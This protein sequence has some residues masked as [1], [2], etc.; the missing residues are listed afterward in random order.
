MGDV[1]VERFQARI[2]LLDPVEGGV[3][4]VD[5]LA[6]FRRQGRQLQAPGEFRRRKFLRL[7]R[8]F[9]QGLEADT[10]DPEPQQCRQ[11]DAHQC[12]A[13]QRHQQVMLGGA[14]VLRVDGNH[15]AQRRALFLGCKLADQ[16][17]EGIIVTRQAQVA[18]TRGAL[19][20]G[21]NLRIR[22][23]VFVARVAADHPETDALVF[24]PQQLE[25]GPDLGPMLRR[26]EAID[27]RLQHAVAR[28]QLGTWQQPQ[29]TVDLLVQRAADQ[30]KDQ[31]RHQ[32]EH[33]TQAQ[34]DGI[35]DHCGFPACD[36]PAH[37][38]CHEW[39]AAACVRT[40]RRAWRA[41]A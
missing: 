16:H 23:T 7:I 37:S 28:I 5:E 1:G 26:A 19:G 8:E 20:K 30:Q 4:R 13:D 41:G 10:R 21:T 14:E 34:G 33:A 2:R 35:S 32:G 22:L 24:F 29:A 3:E 9:A 25:L 38:P 6:Q 12:Q 36:S 39:C 15:E 40:A 31:Q 18:L 17:L 11:Y 27:R